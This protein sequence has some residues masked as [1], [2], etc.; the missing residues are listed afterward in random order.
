ME[1]PGREQEAYVSERIEETSGMSL[2]L[3]QVQTLGEEGQREQDAVV[4]LNL[5][6]VQVRG[7]YHHNVT[8]HLLFQ[9][10]EEVK[11]D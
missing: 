10:E 3:M 1:G 2:G 4:V 8:L 5:G 7:L 6:R 9:M 11:G